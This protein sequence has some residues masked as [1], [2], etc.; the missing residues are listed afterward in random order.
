MTANILSIL[1]PSM[2][3]IYQKFSTQQMIRHCNIF[4]KGTIILS[5][6]LLLTSDAKFMIMDVL[7]MIRC[8]SPMITVMSTV[9]WIMMISSGCAR[10]DLQI[11]RQLQQLHPKNNNLQLITLR[12]QSITTLHYLLYLSPGPVG[13]LELK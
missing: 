7:E 6:F 8:R 2:M 12:Y 1:S 5:E 9:L 11:P 10:L 3:R 13:Q 4:I